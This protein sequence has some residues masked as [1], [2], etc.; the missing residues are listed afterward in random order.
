MTQNIFYK[1]LIGVAIL[2]VCF[3]LY[4]CD[5]G[6]DYKTELSLIQSQKKALIKERDDMKLGIK[7]TRDSLKIAFTTIIIAKAETQQAKRETQI[8]QT[9]YEKIIF[10]GYRNDHERDSICAI[11]YPSFR[12]VRQ[13]GI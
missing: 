7:S 9:R 1:V 2:S 13:P 11:L 6:R 3:N 12:P 5:N 8:I 10:I 4:Q